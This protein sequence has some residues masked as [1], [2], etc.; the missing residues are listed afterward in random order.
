MFRRTPVLTCL[1]WSTAYVTTAWAHK[2]IFS[3]TAAQDA[4]SAIYID[5]I[6]VSYVVYHEVT[7]ERP[8][9]WLSFDGAAG[10]EVW[11]QLG[12]PLIERLDDFR[13]ALVLLG[14]GLPDVEL[15][16]AIPDGLGG[17]LLTTDDV[18]EPEVFHEPFTGTDSW[19]LGNL[20]LTQPQMG[21]YY[22]V[23]Y[24]PGGET[25]KL[26]VA[27]GRRE[28]FG[29]GDIL[30]LPATIQEVREFHETPVSGVPCFLPFV[31]IALAL[32]GGLRLAAKRKR[33]WKSR[34]ER[35]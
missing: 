21:L 13:P 14:P 26:W 17:V 22:L 28:V 11:A 4:E 25:G 32:A 24:V 20:E 12:V 8:L 18:A 9:L 31:G 34:C 29:L 6:T 33:R 7:A 1:I 16:F 5:D 3:R 23:A 15:P 10:Q 19:I 35:S 2:P 30:S 27:P